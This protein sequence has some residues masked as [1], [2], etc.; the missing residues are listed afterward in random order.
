M[1]HQRF[2]RM[3]RLIGTTGSRRALLGAL[4]GAAALAPGGAAPAAK[5]RRRGR[6]GRLRGQ[7]AAPGCY[8]GSP[9]VPGSG[10]NL[11]GCDFSHSD[12][13]TGEDLSGANL[14]GASLRGA[15]ATGANLRKANLG[16]ACLVDADLSGAALDGTT[17]LKG[18][19]FCRTRLPNGKVNNTGCRKGT[20]CCRTC[21]DFGAPCGEGIPRSCCD[22]VACR[23]G[24]CGGCQSDDQCG[25]DRICCDTVCCASGQVCRA[26]RCAEPSCEERCGGGDCTSCVNLVSGA[27]V[28]SGPFTPPTCGCN[29]DAGCTG[30]AVCI[31]GGDD[32][33]GTSFAIVCPGARGAC[34][35]LTPCV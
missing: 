35:T 2:D 17:N 5:R 9:C 23:E 24:F 16:R 28:C 18:A 1:D 10:A 26:G 34:A 13:V 21:I 11:V 6:G 7:Q 3:A 20:R 30:D 4:L 27:T 15:D 12:L 14:S 8:A 19:V 32:I 33:D 31:T 29:S 25:D 22:G